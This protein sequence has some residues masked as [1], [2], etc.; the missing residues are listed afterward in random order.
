LPESLILAIETSSRIGSVAIALGSR[1]I[2]EVRFSGPLRHSMEIFPVIHG[3]LDHI[4]RV[5]GQIE[6]IYISGGPG[7]FTGLRIAVTLAKIMNLA[8][9][10]KIITVN[11]LD[12]IVAN[13][14]RLT[15]GNA[16]LNSDVQAVPG[17]CDRI[18][19]V[20]DAKRGQFFI[21]I[22][23]R[24][25]HGTRRKRIDEF[26]RK[27]V[28]DTLI[29]ISEFHN[30]FTHRKK[31]IGLLGDGLVYYRDRFEA[32]GV[33]FLDEQYWTPRA[34]KVYHLGWQMALEGQF[35]DPFTLIPNY[36]RKP[37]VKLKP[38]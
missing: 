7:S 17:S 22:Y 38:R 24:S 14:V 30:C 8:N 11:T 28:P 35:A 5:P 4:D 36:L 34:N 10:A 32:E 16:Q 23:E 13:A 12:I 6:Q 37:D 15:P 27:I 31:P 3:L 1:L 21:A 9:A 2:S 29:T 19:A 20:L 33:L 26:W 25:T 18:A